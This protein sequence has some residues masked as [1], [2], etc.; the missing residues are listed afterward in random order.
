MRT[1]PSLPS[2]QPVKETAQE[3]LLRDTL[4]ERVDLSIEIDSAWMQVAQRLPELHQQAKPASRFRF[5]FWLPGKQLCKVRPGGLPMVATLALIA[6]LLMGAGIAT[7]IISPTWRTIVQEF[8]SS[9]SQHVPASQFQEVKQ[10]RISN[11]VAITVETAYADTGR[12][13]IG[14]E[15]QL[16]P[17]LISQGF[18]QSLLIDFNFVVNGQKESL[19]SNGGVHQGMCDGSDGKDHRALCL[20]LLAPVQVPDNTKE[21]DITWNLTSITLL[22][23][24]PGAVRSQTL[25]GN[26]NFH[27][28]LL[29][30]HQNHDPGTPP[31]PAD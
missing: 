21:L 12:T 31:T 20:W 3:R 16:S 13:I 26:W 6:I 9:T 30:H 17:E 25:S 11:G 18:S 15:I 22:H 7:G 24:R 28:T 4:H 19:M 2:P 8:L 23:L 14:Y 27:F 29:F 5:P 10:T 1:H